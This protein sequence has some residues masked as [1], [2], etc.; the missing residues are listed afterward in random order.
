M[1]GS[2][3]SALTNLNA[4]ECAREGLAL[5]SGAEPCANDRRSLSSLWG[6]PIQNRLVVYRVIRPAEL[7]LFFLFATYKAIA[8]DTIIEK[9]TPLEYVESLDL[10]QDVV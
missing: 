6:L 2:S 1:Y 9:H 7:S 4:S 8:G 3:V 10:C 5:G